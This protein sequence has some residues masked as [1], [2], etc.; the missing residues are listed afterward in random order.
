M[1]LAPSIAAEVEAHLVSTTGFPKSPLFPRRDG[2][3][4]TANALGT[5]GGRRRA[6]SGWASSTCT[7]SGTPGSPRPPRLEALPAN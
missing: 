2:Q 5:P 3:A 1:V 4:I 6:A 7:T